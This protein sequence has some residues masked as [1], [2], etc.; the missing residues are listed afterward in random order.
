MLFIG[1]CYGLKINLLI[2]HILWNYE[3][4]F[5]NNGILNKQYNRLWSNENPLWVVPTDFQMCWS[6]N[7][8]IGSINGKLLG[9][10][11]YEKTFNDK[12]VSIFCVMF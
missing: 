7:V 10:Y 3:S 9:L 8:W 2:N 1:L 4:N 11:F 12:N 6:T 5:T